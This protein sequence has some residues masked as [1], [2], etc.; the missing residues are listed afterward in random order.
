MTRE[1][2]NNLSWLIIGVTVLIALAVLFYSNNNFYQEFINESK[3]LQNY[4][5]PRSTKANQAFIELDFGNGKKR[6]FRGEVDGRTYDLKSSLELIAKE[7]QFTFRERSGRIE[8][9]ADIGN[10]SGVWKI[11]RNGEKINLPLQELMITG[12]DKYVLRFEK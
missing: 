8:K 6:A 7:A 9:L 11:Y 3:S 1:I 12:G 10:A 4:V 2:N 5:I